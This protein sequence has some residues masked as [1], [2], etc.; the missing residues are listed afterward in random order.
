M[1][2]I[3]TLQTVAQAEV[4]A[5]ILKQQQKEQEKKQKEEQKEQ[6]RRRKEVEKRLEQ[7]RVKEEKERE[8]KEKQ[9]QKAREKMATEKAKKEAEKWKTVAQTQALIKG[10]EKSRPT[11]YDNL[12]L[13]E[14]EYYDGRVV[15]WLYYNWDRNV[16]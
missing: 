3:I 2:N 7:I 8:K 16:K 4:S 6:E 10:C 11:H 13:E 9:E 15:C 14:E 12:T 5:K 1:S